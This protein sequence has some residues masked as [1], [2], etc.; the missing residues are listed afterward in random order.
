[1]DA[2]SENDPRLD[3]F[4]REYHHY[5][6]ALHRAAVRDHGG[7]A[8]PPSFTQW[9]GYAPRNMSLYHAVQFAESDPTGERLREMHDAGVGL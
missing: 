3:G 7:R 9:L 8:N 4:R 6:D 1:M 2:I 5:C